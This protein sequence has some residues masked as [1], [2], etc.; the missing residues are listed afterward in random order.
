[1]VGEKQSFSVSKLEFKFEIIFFLYF[2]LSYKLLYNHVYL[3]N[4]L[5]LLYCKD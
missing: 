3:S 1:M 4:I 5:F 2:H